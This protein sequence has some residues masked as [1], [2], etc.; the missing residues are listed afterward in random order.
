MTDNISEK[1][2]SYWIKF[3]SEPCPGSIEVFCN[4]Y[5]IRIILLWTKRI[6]LL[7]KF[8]CEELHSANRKR[9]KKIPLGKRGIARML[10]SIIWYRYKKIGLGFCRLLFLLLTENLNFR[11]FHSFYQFRLYDMW[12]QGLGSDFFFD[13]SLI[14]L[15]RLSIPHSIMW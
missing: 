15:L 7:E 8:F 2:L 6:E 5:G 14:V 12:N 11:K 10:I 13:F 4:Y 9:I 3:C 1:Y